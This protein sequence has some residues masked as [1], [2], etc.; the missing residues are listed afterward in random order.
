[1]TL[2]VEG[3]TCG[4]C[5]ATVSAA[6]SRLAGIQEVLVSYEYM[7]ALVQ[8]DSLLVRPSQL[9]DAVNSVGLFRPDPMKTRTMLTT[10]IVGALLAAVCCFTPPTAGNE[11]LSKV[12]FRRM[13]QAAA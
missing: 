10:G 8:Y 11:L 3:M 1:M 5:E 6:I 12:V 2:H 4:G 13:I 9:V 7:S